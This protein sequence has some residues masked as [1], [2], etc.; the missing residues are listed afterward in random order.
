MC[1]GC[2]FTFLSRLKHP[3]TES[4]STVACVCMRIMKR[5]GLQDGGRQPRHPPLQTGINAQLLQFPPDNYLCLIDQTLL[6]VFTEFEP[7]PSNIL[8]ENSFWN[9]TCNFLAIIG[10]KHSDQR[11]FTE[12]VNNKRRFDIYVKY[13]TNAIVS[14]SFSP[15]CLAQIILR[16]LHAFIIHCFFHNHH[17]FLYRVL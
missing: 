12:H 14:H 2:F 5:Q 7:H 8:W 16:K 9:H 10:A 6:H 1:D 11:N 13:V 4:L 15:L 17:R 3:F